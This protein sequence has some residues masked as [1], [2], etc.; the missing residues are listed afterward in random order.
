MLRVIDVM[1]SVR[2]EFI[3]KFKYCKFVRLMKTFRGSNLMSLLSRSRT[4]SCKQILNSSPF[5][6]TD[7][8]LLHELII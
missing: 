6:S 3:D 5:A 1:I 7:S 8:M 2:R 4:T